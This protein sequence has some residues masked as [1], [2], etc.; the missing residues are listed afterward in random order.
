[1][2]IIIALALMVFLCGSVWAQPT[3]ATPPSPESLGIQAPPPYSSI[4]GPP[5]SESSQAL[6]PTTQEY[7]MAAAPSTLTTSTTSA[8]MMVVPTGTSTTN[9]FYIPY[10]PSTVASCYFDQWVPMWLDV[11]GYGP[12][13]SYEW[14]P[15]GEV[16]SQYL[17]YGAYPSW[18]KMWFY[19]DATGWH[20]L[21]YYCHGWSNYIYV[22]VSSEGPSAPPPVYPPMPPQGHPPMPP[23]GPP[24]SPPHPAQLPAPSVGPSVTPY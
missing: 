10:Y 8:Y 16:V 13:Y 18:K 23:Q 9:Q 21:Q 22:Y 4:Q 2:R 19:G 20:I 11:K 3:P 17:A 1:M 14:Y 6:A 5:A 24:M 7:A 12:L 15:N